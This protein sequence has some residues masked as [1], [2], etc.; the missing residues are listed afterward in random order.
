MI[1]AILAVELTLTW[2]HMSGVY[3][4]SST[5][6]VIPLVAGLGIMTTVCWKLVK[7]FSGTYFI[8]FVKAY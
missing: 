2:N 3:N 4:V 6:Q 7:K 8:I 1:W 5:G